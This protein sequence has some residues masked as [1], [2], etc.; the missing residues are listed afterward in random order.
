MQIWQKLTTP[1]CQGATLA[2]REQVIDR[3]LF[4]KALT[5][6]EVLGFLLPA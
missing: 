1:P 4:E 6:Y 2:T 3:L 5:P